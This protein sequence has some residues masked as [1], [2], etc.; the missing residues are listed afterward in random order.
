[1][2]ISVIP[3]KAESMCGQ[4]SAPVWTFIRTHEKNCY[5]EV[6]SDF[7]RKPVKAGM[8]LYFCGVWVR[9]TFS[10]GWQLQSTF[11]IGL[12]FGVA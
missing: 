11:N 6:D 4:L 7:M 5:G 3:L 2:E 12:R 10:K 9:G 8:I 1:M